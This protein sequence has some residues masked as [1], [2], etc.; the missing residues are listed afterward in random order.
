M[1]DLDINKRVVMSWSIEFKGLDDIIHNNCHIGTSI[2]IQNL[3]SLSILRHLPETRLGHSSE[4]QNHTLSSRRKE[5]NSTD[6]QPTIQESR[7]N[8]LRPR[9]PPPQA[10]PRPW[11][12]S[13]SSSAAAAQITPTPPSSPRPTEALLAAKT[14]PPPPRAAASSA[15][16]TAAQSSSSPRASRAAYRFCT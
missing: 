15:W 5:A 7:Q 3:T 9:T 12:P 16:A 2:Y 8:G 14:S 10:S 13:S 11:R 4:H 1:A 6:I